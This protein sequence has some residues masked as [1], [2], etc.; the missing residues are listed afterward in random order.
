MEKKG[1]MMLK[2]ELSRLLLQWQH[3]WKDIC[4][5]KRRRRRMRMGGWRTLKESKI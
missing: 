4:R 5:M 1:C 2:V 3:C